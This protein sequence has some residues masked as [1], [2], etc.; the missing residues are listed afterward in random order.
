[1]EGLSLDEKVAKVIEWNE[2]TDASHP[3]LIH[4]L[5]WASMLLN[6]KEIWDYSIQHAEYLLKDGE[7]LSSQGR[8]SLQK[9]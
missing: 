5:E 7:R 8:L 6:S 2:I 4:E 1:M 9:P 3:L